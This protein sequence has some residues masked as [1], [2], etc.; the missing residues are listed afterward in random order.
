MLNLKPGD[1][2][3]KIISGPSSEVACL[4]RVK[5]VK[6]NGIRTHEARSHYDP[7]TGIELNPIIPGW[8]SRLVEIDGGQAELANWAYRLVE[9]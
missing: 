6:E 3:I 9:R 7:K 8:V 1:F 5:T 4:A 2:C